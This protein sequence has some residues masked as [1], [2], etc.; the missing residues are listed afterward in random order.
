[1]RQTTGPKGNK[2]EFVVILHENSPEWV[3]TQ[4]ACA[5]YGYAYVPLYM[6]MKPEIMKSIFDEIPVSIVVC[7]SADQ[8]LAIV[9]LIGFRVKNYILLNRDQHSDRFKRENEQNANILYYEEFMDIE[10]NEVAVVL[11]TS[12]S[13]G[14]MKPVMFTHDELTF[15][16]KSLINH[17]EGKLLTRIRLEY[18]KSLTITPHVR[19][20]LESLM[21]NVR[22]NQ[23]KGQYEQSGFD[24]WLYFKKFRKSF[25]GHVCLIICSGA[26]LSPEVALFFRVAFGCPILQNYGVT[27][28]AGMVS[29]N[30]LGDHELGTCGAILRG[31]QVK[32]ADLPELGIEAEKLH[33]GEV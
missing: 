25:G 19:K 26:C 30:L 27:E 12:G 20:R 11:Y 16:Y 13:E 7:S 15:G 5:A 24:D 33:M 8:A 23:N 17:L 32:L 22:A 10:P 3:I 2:T 18:F 1:M 29:Q 31:L 9:D 6:N 28:T 21:D 4:L 14:K